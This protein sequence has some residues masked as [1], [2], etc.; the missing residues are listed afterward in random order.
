MP[1]RLLFVITEDWAFLTHRLPMARAARDAGY[2]VHV[3]G[4]MGARRGEIDAEGF[5]SYDLPLSRGGFSPTRILRTAWEIR[6]LM[7][8]LRPVIVH[9][10]GIKPIIASSSAALVSPVK[11]VINGLAGRGTL[12]A[13]NGRE[14]EAIRQ[15]VGKLLGFLLTR[16]YSWALVQNPDDAAFLRDLGVPQ[17]RIRMILGSGV[18]TAHFTVL[19]EPPPPVTAAFVGRMVA[20]KGVPTIVEAHEILRH[21]GVELRLLLVGDEDPENPGSLAPEQL[22]EFASAFNIH[23][24]GHKDDVRE[25]WKEAHF[26][27]LG[28]RGGEGLPK[29]LLEAA[30]CG[31]PMVATDVPGSREIVIDGETGFLVPPDDPQAFADAM[32]KLAGDAALRQRMGKNAR[33]R[34][35]QKFSADRVGQETVALYSELL[36]KVS[37]AG[38]S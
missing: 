20:V 14:T 23:W 29:T 30:A 5:T 28:S 4:R 33:A 6:R 34:V 7:R 9:N 12:F 19:P 13:D 17:D 22:R 25:V 10:V 11:L 35:E 2:E 37:E 21:R 3:A 1:R 15:L 24:L 27:V 16:A 18:D 8:K 36:A 38:K 31:R 32:E 26:A